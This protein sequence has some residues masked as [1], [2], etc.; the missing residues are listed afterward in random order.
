MATGCVN[1]YASAYPSGYLS[2]AGTTP[3]AISSSTAA[4][5]AG[6]TENVCVTCTNGVG[7]QTITFDNYAITQDPNICGTAIVD[8]S[9]PAPTDPFSLIYNS[10]TTTETLGDVLNECV[11]GIL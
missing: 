10:V 5:L 4:V 2:V 11:P 6:W 8:Q 7:I 9:A 3:F 1:T